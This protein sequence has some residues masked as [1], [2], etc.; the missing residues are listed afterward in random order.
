MGKY[1]IKRCKLKP[2][3]I[4]LESRSDVS[5]MP[6][7]VV[8]GDGD[9]AYRRYFKR[10][11]D[12]MIVLL[13]ALPAG[14][15]IGVLALLV[16]CD[17]H[18]PFYR[19]PRVGRNGRIFSMWKLRTMVPAAE[20]VL[21]AYLASS[22]AARAEWAHHQKLRHDPRVTPIG[23]ILRRTSLDEL[24]Q[25]WNVARGEMSIVGPRPIMKSQTGLYPGVEY[26]LLLPGI[27]GFWQ[28]SERNAT[29]FHERAHFDR[30]YFH[31]LSFITDIRII[32]RTFAV[33]LRATGQ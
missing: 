24:P 33:V 20:S 29:S 14:A 10:L 28:T 21:E 15:L 32:L 4:D 25:L 26:Y 2:D 3:L 22:P 17:G 7:P 12:A 5:T 6:L 18:N 31:R 30:A 9:G 27:T 8:S 1:L 19:Q 13:A 23:R 11:L 16:A